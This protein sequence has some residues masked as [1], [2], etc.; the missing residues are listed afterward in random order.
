MVTIRDVAKAAGVSLTTVSRAYNPKA[1][2][3]QST[4]E[5]ILK[6][7]HEMGYVPNLSARS[8]VTNQKFVLGVFFSNLRSGTPETFL[9]TVINSVY[10]VLPDDYLLSVNDIAHLSNF[11]ARVQ[12]RMA[13]VLVVSQSPDDDAFIQ[14][15]AQAQ[16]PTVVINRDLEDPLSYNVCSDDRLGVY[17]AMQYLAQAG[18]Q[19]VGMIA[20]LPSYTSAHQRR[21]GFDDGVADFGLTRVDAAMRPG[22]YSAQAGRKQMQAILDLPSDQRPTAV[23]CADDDTAVGALRACYQAGV[24]VPAGMSV[25]GF[26]DSIYAAM[27]VPALTTVKKPIVQMATA[28]IAKLLALIAG[29]VDTVVHKE[30]IAPSLIVRESVLDRHK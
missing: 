11:E 9:S 26:D 7:A 15:L 29:E 28:G 13:G 10:E 24:S 6:L 19:R 2:I 18:H 16:I 14:R 5:R 4:R 12:M 25:V 3:R 1:V 22:N 20:G 17:K 8:L 27:S 21:Q 23:I 30:V